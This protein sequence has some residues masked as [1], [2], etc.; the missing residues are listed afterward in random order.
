MLELHEKIRILHK[1]VWPI[2][3]ILFYD[4]DSQEE[5]LKFM[6]NDLY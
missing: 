3:F 5:V 6:K 2:V 1:V 4:R